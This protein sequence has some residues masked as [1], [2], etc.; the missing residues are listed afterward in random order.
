MNRQRQETTRTVNIKKVCGRD[1]QPPPLTWAILPPTITFSAPASAGPPGTTAPTTITPLSPPCQLP[2][3]RYLDYQKVSGSPAVFLE[4]LDPQPQ[5]SFGFSDYFFSPIFY[6]EPHF[7]MRI[8]RPCFFLHPVSNRGYGG[9]Q[10][11]GSSQCI[12]SFRHSSHHSG[13]AASRMG[14]KFCGASSPKLGSH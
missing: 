7:P 6:S 14:F 4:G 5:C 12:T 10:R 1:R 8:S 11:R 2:R 9:L 3:F 13:R